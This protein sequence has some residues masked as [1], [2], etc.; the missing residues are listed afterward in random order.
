MLQFVQQNPDIISNNNNNKQINE[1]VNKNT[2]EDVLMLSKDNN[3]ENKAKLNI[4]N[5]KSKKDEL[6]KLIPLS[7]V[8]IDF[9]N[10]KSNLQL[11]NNNNFNLKKESINSNAIPL[12]N[13]SLSNFKQSNSNTIKTDLNYNKLKG[14]ISKYNKNSYKIKSTDG[15]IS[16][17][18][19]Y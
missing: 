17:Y 10:Q 9:S 6:S 8:K 1:N 16:T 3:L 5:S 7:Q 14:N 19:F 11:R 2:K 12:K 13:K 4:K 18:P 15:P